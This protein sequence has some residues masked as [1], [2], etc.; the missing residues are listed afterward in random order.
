MK[1][2]TLKVTD[3]NKKFLADVARMCHLS[4]KEFV[5]SASLRMAKALLEDI[6]AAKQR[7]ADND[8]T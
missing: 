6:R 3:E 5:T 2:I 7:G 1:T 4:T 8:V